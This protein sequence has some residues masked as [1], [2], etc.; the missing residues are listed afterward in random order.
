MEY[1]IRSCCVDDVP[2]LVLLCEK[3]A[4]YENAY[5]DSIDK[6]TLL[7]RALFADKPKL[8]CLVVESERNIVGYASYT[9]DFSTWNAAPF[10]HV[11]CL[12]LEPE[13]R[14]HGIGEVIIAKMKDIAV[15][16]GCAELQWQTPV[17]NHK[18]IKFYKRMLA[19]GKE[20]MRFTLALNKV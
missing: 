17:F 5:Y 13:Y 16:H 9:F 12:Y 8:F 15:Q 19:T 14:G 6:L 10:L 20:K 4:V 3:H 2:A 18:A 1:L 7:S 11:D